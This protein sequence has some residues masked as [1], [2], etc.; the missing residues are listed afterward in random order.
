MEVE[1]RARTKVGWFS[2]WN[3]RCGVAEYSRHLLNHFDADRFDCTVLASYDDQV[4]G[5]DGGNVVRCWGINAG[6]VRPLLEAVSAARF[7]V[8][9][10]QYKIQLGFGWLSLQHFEALMALC[11]LLGT[12][13]IVVAHATD[14]ADLSGRPVSSRMRAA[15]AT[16]ERILVHC[17]ADVER[18]QAFGLSANVELLPHGFPDIVAHDGKSVRARLGI[19]PASFVIG[20]YG[21]MLP[22]KGIDTLIEAFSMLRSA[23]PDARLMLVNAMYPHPISEDY[24]AT[25]ERIARDRG[26]RDQVVL[27][28]RFLSDDESAELLTA[29]DVVVFPYRSGMDSSSAA[30]RVGLASVRPVLCTPASI[31]SD[32]APIV[33]FFDGFEA[34]DISRGLESFIADG[35]AD[36]ARSRRQ[37]A[38]VEE[39]SRRN[40]SLR[41]QGLIGKPAPSDG[42]RRDQAW[43]AAHLQDLVAGQSAN[44]VAHDRIRKLEQA[45]REAQGAVEPIRRERDAAAS[46]L[47]HTRS[48][49]AQADAALQQ[50]RTTIDQSDAALHAVQAS[51]SWRATAPLRYC[52]SVLRSWFRG[53]AQA[54][55]VHQ[56]AAQPRAGGTAEGAPPVSASMAPACA[57]E[58]ELSAEARNV[59]LD[60]ERMAERR[61]W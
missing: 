3:C 6:S 46:T 25:C 43:V 10:L 16:V 56:D 13:V 33:H 28:T 5:P 37:A 21:F 42:T 19:A 53:R 58:N 8:L 57:A 22:A 26:V 49:L 52:E 48:A 9:V 2:T 27:E 59:R 38:W 50:A 20:A 60:L 7:N 30:V 32:V 24:R 11:H 40:V 15:L 1:S 61:K 54:E 41:L 18:L 35:G 14:G 39:H 31:F 34:E 17:D 55:A 23:R 29:A 45:L 36:E 47:E 51:R 44:D 12:R 4:L